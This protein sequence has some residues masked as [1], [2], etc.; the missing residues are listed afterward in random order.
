[1]TSTEWVALV[2][3]IAQIESEGNPQ[4]VGRDRDLGLLQVTPIVIAE[5]HRR[6]GEHWQHERMTDPTYCILFFKR[7]V[8][9]C[10]PA[11][12][13]PERIARQWHRTTDWRGKDASRYWRKVRT[14][15]VRKKERVFN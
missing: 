4:A 6:T 2:Y 13:T 7:F 15:Y 11:N 10:C 5:V 14:V 12:T 8:E 1:M 9:S 3:A